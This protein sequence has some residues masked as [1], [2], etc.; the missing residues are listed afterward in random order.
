MLNHPVAVRLGVL[1][2]SIY[3]VHRLVLG[4]VAEIVPVAPLV[5]IVSLALTI[6]LAEL[7]FRAVEQP[8]ARLRKRLESDGRG[9]AGRKDEVPPLDR[10][11]DRAGL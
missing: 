9:R 3:L 11:G 6:A 2:F 1:S 7:I 4:L 10:S 5:D 8:A